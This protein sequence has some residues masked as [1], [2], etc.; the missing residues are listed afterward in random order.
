MGSKCHKCNTE[1]DPFL[2]VAVAEGVICTTCVSKT[3]S[4]ACNH[5]S[6]PANIVVSS[7]SLKLCATCAPLYENCITC[8][9]LHEVKTMSLTPRGEK[10][11]LTCDSVFYCKCHCCKKSENK[12]HIRFFGHNIVCLNCYQ[13]NVLCR[14]CNLIVPRTEYLLEE[15]ACRICS[16][17]RVPI[18]AYK[19]QATTF[20][21]YWHVDNCG[22]V[23]GT[24]EPKVD[25]TYFGVELEVEV[26]GT[27]DGAGRMRTS[28]A[29]I[30]QVARQV[31]AQLEGFAILKHDSSI[32]HGFEI[33]SAP[34][35]IQAHK[36]KWEKFFKWCESQESPLIQ[37]VETTTCGMHVH[38]SRSCMTT[39]QIGKM[40]QFV[41][42]PTNAAFVKLVAQRNPKAYAEID[43]RRT[44]KDCTKT[45]QEQFRLWAIGDRHIRRTALNTLPKNTIEFRIFKANTNKD[46]FFANIEFCQALMDFCSSGVVSI[47]QSKEA[48]AFCEFVHS[49]CKSYP[50]LHKFLANNRLVPRVLINKTRR[51]AETCV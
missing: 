25:Q 17:N 13:K 45:R 38:I 16:I 28:S 11:C 24:A 15:L 22:G 9:R 49:H 42:N 35:T 31:L 26:V 34:A 27:M 47:S 44:I 39:M 37:T 18:K 32:A 46:Q 2:S 14:C 21:G 4:I 43:S 5:C 51:I 1:V 3:T 8:T 20:C 50:N 33:V 29:R 41:Y 19:T 12:K 40:I 6:K 36:S 30:E 48:P 7:N 23:V 10:V